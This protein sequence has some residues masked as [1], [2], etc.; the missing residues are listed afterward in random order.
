MDAAERVVELEQELADVA[1]RHDGE[2]A[3]LR[4]LLR[5][6]EAVAAEAVEITAQ[7]DHL[8]SEKLRLEAEL[9]G[10]YDEIESLRADLHRVYT[11]HSWRLTAPLRWIAS[12]LRGKQPT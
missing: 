8:A 10:T 12:P 2:Q 6:A 9:R 4:A 3:Q 5:R 11:S 7:R 1:D